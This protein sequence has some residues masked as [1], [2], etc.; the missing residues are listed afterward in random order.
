MA[1]GDQLSGALPP[2]SGLEWVAACPI[3]ATTALLNL[4]LQFKKIT[5]KP[6]SPRFLFNNSV[7]FHGALYLFAFLLV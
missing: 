1:V 2:P 7:R 5:R 3:T 6:T 4:K